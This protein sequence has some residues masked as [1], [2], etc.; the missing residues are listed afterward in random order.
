MV[1]SAGTEHDVDRGVAIPR[2]FLLVVLEVAG[3]GR[4]DLHDEPPGVRG[5]AAECRR[6][7]AAFV[8]GPAPSRLGV[9]QDTKQV[10]LVAGAASSGMHG[11]GY[12]FQ[13]G[14]L[15]S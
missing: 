5:V 4:S 14:N 9:S 10:R 2:V 15:Q 3:H 6:K 8:P 12:E 7:G 13:A 11:A 1:P